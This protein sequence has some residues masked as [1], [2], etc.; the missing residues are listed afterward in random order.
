LPHVTNRPD[1]V[2]MATPYPNTVGSV[3]LEIRPQEL[4]LIAFSL[5]FVFSA[6]YLRI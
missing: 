5:V 2:L 4:F 3:A 1:E 6:L